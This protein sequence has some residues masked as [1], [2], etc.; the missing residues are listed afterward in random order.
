MPG[1]K[2]SAKGKKKAVKKSVSKRM[3]GGMMGPKKK[4]AR[5]GP[6]KRMGGGMLGPKKKMAGGGS[7]GPKKKL[8]KGG[9][10]KKALGRKSS[11]RINMDDLKRARDAKMPTGR[12]AAAKKAA[13]KGVTTRSGTMMAKFKQ[14]KGNP[15]GKDLSF[16]SRI[17]ALLKKGRKTPKAKSMDM[18][19]KMKSK[20]KGA[21]GALGK[22]MRR[23]GAGK[24][25]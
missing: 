5:G 12:S 6:V 4:M 3:G 19:P 15:A 16:N 2:K 14:G 1:K 20:G 10:L 9:A 22:V 11:G 18:G 17:M 25:K 8:A 13:M 24:K 21:I 23:K 7:M